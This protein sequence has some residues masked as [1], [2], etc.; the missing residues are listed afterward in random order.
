MTTDAATAAPSEAPA[1]PAVAPAASPAPA[2]AAAPSWVDATTETKPAEA[3][4]TSTDQAP[5]T[6]APAADA[7]QAPAEEAKPEDK[8][9]ERA[10]PDAY[11]FTA[12]DGVALDKELTA[13]F[14]GLARELNMPQ[15]EAQQLVERMAPKMQARM[16]AA[17]VE[18]LAKARAEWSEQLAADP[19]I[20]G[21]KQQQALATAAKAL[22]A[23]GSDPLRA[24]LKDSGLQGHPEVVRFFVNVG[25][26]MGED[27]FIRGRAPTKT[28]AQGIYAASG[29]NP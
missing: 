3:D 4:A 11:E 2:Q 26:G 25:K 8:P 21:D 16:Q 7:A 27:S 29:M 23:F 24:L 28:S 6:D 20:G 14:E 1:A 18:L 19:E 13:E 15:A 10:A 9:A 12:P 22:G 5:K 17:Q